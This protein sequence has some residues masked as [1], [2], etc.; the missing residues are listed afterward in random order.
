MVQK[1]GKNN[2]VESRRQGRAPGHDFLGERAAPWT[3]SEI[4]NPPGGGLGRAAGGSGLPVDQC[5]SGRGEIRV[6]EQ[7]K[8]RASILAFWAGTESTIKRFLPGDNF[9][10]S[11]NHNG[12]P[13]YRRRRACSNHVPHIAARGKNWGRASRGGALDLIPGAGPPGRRQKWL[14]LFFPDAGAMWG[15]GRAGARFKIRTTICAGQS[16]MGS[17]EG[18]GDSR[19]VVFRGGAWPGSNPEGVIPYLELGAEGAQGSG[20]RGRGTGGTE[21]R[22]TRGGHGRL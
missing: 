15:R 11:R 2:Y 13:R 9:A 1:D 19:S 4:N 5:S 12:L 10:T 14:S 3:V 16:G 6:G 21:G 7:K 17:S 22:K 18:N 8:M 20:R